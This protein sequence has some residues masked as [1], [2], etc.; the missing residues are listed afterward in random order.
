MQH[1]TDPADKYPSPIA[2]GFG[3]D[4]E[5]VTINPKATPY[6]FY[7]C[8]TPGDGATNALL[9]DVRQ[10][11]AHGY[12]VFYLGLKPDYGNDTLVNRPG[13]A[14][15][16]IYPPE[17]PLIVGEVY[18][19]VRERAAHS[20][21]RSSTERPVVLAI[22]NIDLIPGALAAVTGG[23]EG[24]EDIKDMLRYIVRHGRAARV[25]V[26][27]AGRADMPANA[28]GSAIMDMFDR[29]TITS[30]E[31]GGSVLRGRGTDGEREFQ[32]PLAVHP[33]Q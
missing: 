11:M 14:A 28:V 16:S 27:A 33:V 21:D 5:D 15:A 8:D 9:N 26:V 1:Q 6:R 3:D 13:V 30:T 18:D 25:H 12:A 17:F 23:T 10:C 29:Y 4:G 7:G 32:V 20:P 22:D 2:L 19:L 24:W 31:R